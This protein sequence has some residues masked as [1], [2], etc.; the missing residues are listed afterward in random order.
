VITVLA[1]VTGF[2][3]A[4]FGDESQ[5]Y[6]TPQEVAASEWLYRTAPPGAQVLGAN[7]NFPWA[8]VHYDWY[9]YTF[10]DTIPPALGRAVLRAPVKTMI[11]M[12]G[13]GHPPAS[14]LILT[15]SQAAEISLTGTWPPG[16]F[17]RFTHD[18]LASGKFRIVYHNTDATILQLSRCTP[19]GG[20]SR[21]SR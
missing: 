20:E 21:C 4:N 2:C 11:S 3:L 1:L 5:N 17:S 8:F 12:M 14:Y 13:P 6:F 18:L 15:R 10:L 19:V 7:S 9:T 16:E